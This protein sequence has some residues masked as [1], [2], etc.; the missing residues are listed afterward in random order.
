MATSYSAWRRPALMLVS[1]PF[2]TVERPSLQLGLLSAIVRERGFHADTLHL[3]LDF[4][5]RIGVDLYESLSE[6][7]RHEFGNWLFSSAAFPDE[8][9]DPEGRLL[10]ELA[11]DVERFQ[12]LGGDATTLLRI[13]N[14]VVPDFLTQTEQAVDWSRYDVV[15]FTSTFQQ[16]AAS[17]A[18]ARRLKQRHPRTII[19]FGGAN[20]EGEMGREWVRALPFIDYAV[21]GEADDALPDLLSALSNGGSPADVPGVVSRDTE[22][23][24][25]TR[26]PFDRLDDLPD[27]NFDEYFARS[28]ALGLL[29]PEWRDKVDLPFE[30]SRGCWWGARH[31][32]TFCGLNG[33]TMRHRQKSPARVME[34]LATMAQRYGVFKFSAVDNI[35]PVDFMDGLLPTLRN[36]GRQYMLF[37]ETKANLSRA[38]IKTLAEAG[39]GTF[40]PGLESLSSHVLRLMR[41]GV[42]ASQNVN[43]LRWSAHYGVNVLWNILWGFPGETEDD[44]AQQ[45]ALIP[46]LVHLQPPIAASR[47]SFERF[48]PFHADRERFPVSRLDVPASLNFIYPDSIRHE[49]VAYYF[50]HA[51]REELPDAAYEGVARAVEEWKTQWK[52]KAPLLNYRWS[53]GLLHIEDR[54]EPSAPQLYRFDSPL[55]EIYA[56]IVDRALSPD[57]IKE[58]LS[59]FSGAEEI[60]EALNLLVDK[61]LVMRDE[62]LY[63]ALALPATPH[64]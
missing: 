9:P 42:R 50:E 7:A 15:G 21:D 14:E 10:T 56:A 62:G 6:Y 5:V 26:R 8:A 58:R 35:M 49:R 22:R 27:L 4:A 40:Q 60:S 25:A 59:L 32:C 31:H 1:M 33:A 11:P 47:I 19:L 20:F 39:V 24:T 61:G 53:P 44:Y 64:S 13:R 38:N 29:S 45:A 23:R 43:L 30:S 34:E 63:L 57:V 55:S 52:E 46:H 3:T 2:F 41:K 16:N 48:S 54:R 51:F 37:F 18:L 12:P 28:E 36:E 17:F